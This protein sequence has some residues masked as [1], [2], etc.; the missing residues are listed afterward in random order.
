M[1]GRLTKNKTAWKIIYVLCGYILT[2]GFRVNLIWENAQAPLYEGYNGFFRH[3]WVCL[4]AAVMD[5]LVLLLLYFLL[6]AF[7]HSLYWP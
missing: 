7:S 6:A 2:I 3:F 4:V 5:A 1:T